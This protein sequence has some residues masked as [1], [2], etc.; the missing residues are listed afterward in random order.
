[1]I[2]LLSLSLGLSSWPS[3]SGSCTAS[4]HGVSRS[5]STSDPWLTAA[6]AFVGMFT[7]VVT[8]PLPGLLTKKNAEFQQKRMLAVSSGGRPI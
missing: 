8:L 7:I 5:V 6:G 2:C 1:V 3:A 4:S